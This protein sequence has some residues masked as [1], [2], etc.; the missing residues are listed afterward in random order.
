MYNLRK[1]RNN[2]ILNINNNN[3]EALIT[4]VK[5]M[6]NAGITDSDTIISEVFKIVYLQKNKDY[7]FMQLV[8]IY[9]EEAENISRYSYFLLRKYVSSN[10][11]LISKLRQFHK[12]YCETSSLLLMELYL[13]LTNG[14]ID[15]NRIKYIVSK[16]D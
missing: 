7:I 16:C 2:F 6:N 11:E 13:L 5:N 8:N 1:I 9:P 14:I 10:I 3:P 12:K 4:F 15:I